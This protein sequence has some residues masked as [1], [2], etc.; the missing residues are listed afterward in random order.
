MPGSLSDG[1]LPAKL[2][3][4]ESHL[5]EMVQEL[6][7][8]MIYAETEEEFEQLWAEMLQRGEALGM[9]QLNAYYQKEWKQALEKEKV[10]GNSQK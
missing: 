8:N 2:Q 7:W 5:Q 6:S 9:E 4:I 1:R 10:Y 3:T